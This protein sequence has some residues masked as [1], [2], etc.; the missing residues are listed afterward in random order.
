MEITIIEEPAI[1]S[2]RIGH[3]D[4]KARNILKPI[5]NSKSVWRSHA[6]Y[7]LAEYFYSKNQTQKSKEF[8]NQILTLENANL[9]IVKETQKRLNRDLS[10]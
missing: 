4:D 5:I 10:E 3:G 6:L 1:V 2:T 8:Y 7:W 9:D